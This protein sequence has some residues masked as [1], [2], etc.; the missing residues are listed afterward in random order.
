MNLK[1]KINS[2]VGGPKFEKSFSLIELLIIVVIFTIISGI[3]FTIFREFEPTM[4]LNGA[5]RELITDLRYA[6]QL[7]VSEQ[8]RHGIRFSTTTPETSDEYRLIRHGEA[9]EEIFTKQLSEGIEFQKINFTNQEV[10]FNS[11]GA[12]QEAGE[13]VLVNSKNATTTIDVRPSGFIQKK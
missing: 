5:A 9:P 8:V 7:T 11:Y 2:P 3:S 13:V 12:V 1:S 4:K 10:I 6:Q